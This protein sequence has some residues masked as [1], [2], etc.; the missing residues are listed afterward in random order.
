MEK[1]LHLHLSIM[2]F[3]RIL[4]VI[5]LLNLSI[6]HFFFSCHSSSLSLSFEKFPYVI[7]LFHLSII[8]NRKIFIL[9]LYLSIINF[10]FSSVKDGKEEFMKRTNLFEKK[11]DSFIL[12]FSFICHSSSPSFYYSF[13]LFLS[14]FFS[15]KSIFHLFFS[16]VILLFHISIIHFFFSCHDK[17]RKN[18]SKDGE[19]E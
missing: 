11:N 2:N 3:R 16:Y 7:L 1:I 17:K 13:L 15:I 19:D 12:F 5:L 8:H 4:D 10:F 9:L 14:F 18:L 6:I